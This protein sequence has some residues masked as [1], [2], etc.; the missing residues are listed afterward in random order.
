VRSFRRRLRYFIDK[1]EAEESMHHLMI[2][3]SCSIDELCFSS[4]N[5]YVQ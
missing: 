1:R 2:D 5:G 4:Q 3:E